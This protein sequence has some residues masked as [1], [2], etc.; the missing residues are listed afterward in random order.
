MGAVKNQGGCGSC[1]AFSATSVLEA[2]ISIL[3]TA[4][5]S[6]V[7]VPP[8]RLSEQQLVDCTL[9]GTFYNYGC[10]GGWSD[11]AWGYAKETGLMLETDYPYT[12]GSTG[13]TGATC[14]FDSSKPLQKVLSY[15]YITPASAYTNLATKG[16]IN[17][18]V[19][20]SCSNF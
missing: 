19:Y 3:K 2:R 13:L 9:T 12:S 1:W 8:V 11:S 7:L 5:A 16:P 17:I 4:T 20:A 15:G 14:N 18:Y 10:N 6:G